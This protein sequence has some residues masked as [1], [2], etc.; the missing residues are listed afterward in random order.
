MKKIVFMGTPA[1]S[2]PSLK[3]LVDSPDYEVV[4]V[5]TQPDREVG[6]KRKLTPS[7]V[8]EAALEAGLPVYQ[9]EKIGQDQGV[10]EL[11]DSGVDLLV[12]AAYGQFLPERLLQ[13]PRYGAINLHASLLPKYRGGAPVHYAIWKGEKQ[14]GITIMRMV[15]KMD[16]GPILTQATIAIESETTVSELFDQLSELAADLLMDT[17]PDLFAG[18]LEEVEQDEELATFSP[19]ITREQERIDW[20]QTAQVIHDQIRAFNAWPVAHT[21]WNDKRWKIW[22]SRVVE[23]EETQQKPGTLIKLAKKPAAF[24]IACGQG[25]VLAITEIQP[26]GKKAMVIQNFLNGGAGHFEVGDKFQSACD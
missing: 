3:T 15:K 13:L 20:H 24:W 1:F 21:I 22:A 16:A 5:V 4:G 17:L 23:G 11:L 26:A 12:T 25:T 18:V 6:R 14:T 19:N 2:V 7:P 9:P 10:E 8:K